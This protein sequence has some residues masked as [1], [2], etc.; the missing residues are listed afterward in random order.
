MEIPPILKS[1]KAKLALIVIGLLVLFY[2]LI[3]S[4]INSI[5][6]A[7]KNIDNYFTSVSENATRR[8]ELIPQFAKLVQDN[9]PQAKEILEELNKAYQVAKGP[10]DKSIL[11]NQEA[12]QAFTAKQNAVTQ[13]LKYLIVQAQHFPAIGE[14]RQF[15]ILKMQLLS[16]DQ[17]IDYLTTL[18][19]REILLFNTHLIGFPK[20]WLNRFLI[21]EK[22]KLLLQIPTTTQMPQQ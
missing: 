16:F 21:G 7:N 9:A 11:T 5:H 17:Q 14:N 20:S 10:I 18:L 6:V 3:G 8:V 19:N 13:I 22:V 15:I 1:P 4:W 12:L 2:L